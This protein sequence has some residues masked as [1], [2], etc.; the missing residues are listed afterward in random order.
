[1]TLDAVLRRAIRRAPC[2]IRALAREAGVSHSML[3]A[4][5]TGRERATPRVALKLAGALERWAARCAKDAAAVRAAVEG[6]PAK[7]DV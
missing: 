7:G 3:A 4:I 1:M 6:R 5:V 2:S